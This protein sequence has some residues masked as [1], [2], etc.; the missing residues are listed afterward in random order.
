[1]YRPFLVITRNP[2]KLIHK[3]NTLY[4]KTNAAR[5]QG[6]TRPRAPDSNMPIAGASLVVARFLH[7]VRRQQGDHK[8][9][10]YIIRGEVR[11]MRVPYR[12]AWLPCRAVGS[13]IVTSS[14]AA[15]GCTAMVASMSALVAPIFTAMLMSW[16]ISPALSPTMWTPTTRSVAA[17]T[18]IF[19]NIRLWRPD[20]VAL[21][22]RNIDL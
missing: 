1:P 6:L 8:A 12:S 5:A 9:R 14:S 11:H 10:P 21:R 2:D 4:R 3:T 17:S 7:G 16:I 15:V 22:G 18:T 19:I 20:S 13:R